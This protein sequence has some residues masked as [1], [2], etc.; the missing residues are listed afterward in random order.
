MTDRSRSDTAELLTL[1]E[2]LSRA[3]RVGNIGRTEGG[4]MAA[5]IAGEAADGLL[6]IRRSADVL[7]RELLPRLLSLPPEG[8]DFENALDDIAEEY[9]HIHYHISNTRLFN[10]VVPKG[11]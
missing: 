4:E 9:R 2:L 1:T 5:E 11:Q 8:R 6:D 10:Y 3:P 7:F